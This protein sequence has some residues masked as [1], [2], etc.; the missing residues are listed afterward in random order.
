MKAFISL[1]KFY[2]SRC[3]FFAAMAYAGSAEAKFGGYQLAG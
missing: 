3:R 1:L 2:S